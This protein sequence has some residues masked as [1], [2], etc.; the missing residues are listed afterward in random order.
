MASEN[1]QLLE[2]DRQPVI[3]ESRRVVS[4]SDNSSHSTGLMYVFCRTVGLFIPGQITIF[5]E[6][7][8][9]KC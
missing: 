4:H 5:G 7:I 2:S 9:L 1:I 8:I 6:M 3:F